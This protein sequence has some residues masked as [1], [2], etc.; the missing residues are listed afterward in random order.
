MKKAKSQSTGSGAKKNSPKKEVGG[1][2]SETG[3]GG[4]LAPLSSQKRSTPR[5][6]TVPRDETTTVPRDAG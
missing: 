2:M 3:K 6:T 4:G 5:L 1:R